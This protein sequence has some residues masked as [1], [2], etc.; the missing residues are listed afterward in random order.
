MNRSLLVFP[1]LLGLCTTAHCWNARFQPAETDVSWPEPIGDTMRAVFLYNYGPGGRTVLWGR[2]SEVGSEADLPL[3]AQLDS[4]GNVVWSKRIAARMDDGPS[5]FSFA[6]EDRI[7]V[8]YRAETG[9]GPRD[10]IGL[11]DASGFAP[12]YSHSLEV[13]EPPEGT[14]GSRH[15][16]W[17]ANG[18]MAIVQTL[19]HVVKIQIL[20][21]NGGERFARTYTLP[22]AGGGVT[23]PGFQTV[24]YSASISS[25]EG[26]GYLVNAHTTRFLEQSSTLHILKLAA[27][28][29]ITWQAGAD[30][31]YFGG[32]SRILEDGRI[33]LS[34][35][36][37]LPSPAF[38]IAVLS[39]SGVLEWGSRID[40]LSYGLVLPDPGGQS[41]S[42]LVNGFLQKGAMEEGSTDSVLLL[43]NSS[44]A[45]IAETACDL[46]TGDFVY[47]LGQMGGDLFFEFNAIG[48]SGSGLTHGI[49]ARIGTDLVP[50]A[51]ASFLEKAG[52][53]ASASTI[54][55]DGITPFLSY[56]DENQDW[57]YF[58]EI[59]GFLEEV[60]DCDLLVP[61][62]IPLYD[63]DLTVG[64]FSIELRPND[65]TGAAW[66]DPPARSA[67]SIE[68][69]DTPLIREV[70]CGGSSQTNPWESIPSVNGKGDKTTGIGCIND[71]AYPW[72]W[73]HRGHG[74]LYFVPDLS[75]LDSL[76]GYD[77]GR[78]T[79][80][81]TGNGLGGW[82]YSF[83]P[84][85][86]WAHW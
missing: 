25:L 47:H 40:G 54:F 50:V 28:G 73:H 51:T 21:G 6:T 41:G 8:A 62:A 20:D 83:G 76:Y 9:Q 72:V 77:F 64:D 59:T 16:S 70:V 7:A 57:I 65:V 22:D 38:C 27:N 33:L 44:G 32:T 13:Y 78:G 19:D 48:S 34:A 29:S 56:R 1:V 45:K 82:H 35:T 14:D 2:V 52:S 58:N 43:L 81:W 24:S 10:I 11:I 3:L 71:S 66:P 80:F 74:F 49:L 4:G 42:W 23:I 86:G 55:G 61:A 79:W 69:V 30:F 15:Y 17:L 63:P 60:G 18:E 37:V 31:S 75:G 5:D 12:V 85:A 53:S 46:E 26:E 68:I 36:E 84:H 39:P 67:G